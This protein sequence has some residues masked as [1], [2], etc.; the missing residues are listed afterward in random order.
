MNVKRIT[1]LLALVFALAGCATKVESLPLQA[2]TSRTQQQDVALYFGAQPHPRVTVALG[3]RKLSLRIARASEDPQESCNR[4]LADA[5]QRLRAYA[6][7][8]HGNAVIN[9]KTRFHTTET[10]SDTDYTCGV[11]PSAAAIAVRG[12]VVMLEGQ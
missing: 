10:A 9:I 8:L 12:D 6:R 2:V 11:S 5:M 7:E 1:G 4:A 3:E